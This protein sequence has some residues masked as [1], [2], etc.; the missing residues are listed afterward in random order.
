VLG[1]ARWILRI[2]RAR[3]RA[4]RALGVARDEMLCALLDDRERAALTAEIY[5]K[6]RTFLPGGTAFRSG[7]FK[8]EEHALAHP[9]FP[10]H[11]R[12]LIGGAGGG[13]EM[14][15]LCER[16]YEVVAF[17]PSDLVTGA[18]ETASRIGSRARAL[19]GS[20]ADL[21]E[22]VEQ[23]RGPLASIA[24]LEHDAVVLG[25]AS[26]AFITAQNERIALLR[27]LR[28]ICP[29]GPVLM[30]FLPN[31]DPSRSLGDRWRPRLRRALRSS[32]PAELRFLAD[33]G[34]V[35]L[36]SRGQ[37]EDLAAQTGY[38]VVSCEEGVEAWCALLAPVR[39]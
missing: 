4:Y 17:E 3:G 37:I 35:I 38:R 18:I 20:Y 5:S 29:N 14:V 30:S 1:L 15:T 12:I 33:N 8:W 19:R 34:F 2:D 31:K 9:L 6:H 7:L 11:G 25:W 24:S 27:V 23:G 13:R 28:R 36:A 22:G 21:I 16:G 26:F 39:P 10:K 32:A